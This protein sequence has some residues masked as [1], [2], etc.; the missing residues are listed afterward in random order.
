LK[1]KTALAASGLALPGLAATGSTLAAS[2]AEGYFSVGAVSVG[3]T[4]GVAEHGEI[5][6]KP[7]LGFVFAE[8]GLL[9][10]LSLEGEKISTIKN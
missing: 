9:C 2:K 10:G 4:L 3:L 5:G 7:I 6:Q 8:K 1:F